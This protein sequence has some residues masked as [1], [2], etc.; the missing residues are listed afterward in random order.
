MNIQYLYVVYTTRT[1]QHT[2]HILILTIV[3]L[4]ET[5]KL[6]TS[7]VLATFSSFRLTRKSIAILKCKS[8]CFFDPFIF[9]NLRRTSAAGSTFLKQ[10][11][12][13]TRKRILFSGRKTIFF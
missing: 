9:A 8:F 12:D 2:Y 3:F 4:D 5:R 6:F 7:R 1:P 11:R 13:Q 10:L